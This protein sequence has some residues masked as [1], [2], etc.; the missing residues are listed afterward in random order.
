MR[1]WVKRSLLLLLLL[2]IGVPIGLWLWNEN[3]LSAE[4][5][6]YV[7][8][9]M[10]EDGW[11]WDCRPDRVLILR[12]TDPDGKEDVRNYRW[13]VE[14]NRFHLFKSDATMPFVGDSSASRSFT[15]SGKELNRFKSVSESG[16]HYVHTRQ[17]PP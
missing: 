7:G 16:D 15:I 11:V 14:G 17:P 12:R 10:T 1:R 5:K 9:W 3:V 13:Y 4:E 8:K 6:G 2:G